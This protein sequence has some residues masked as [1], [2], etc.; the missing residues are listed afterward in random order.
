MCV[1]VCVCVC[2]LSDGS[3]LGA[4]I[5]GKAALIRPTNWSD[6]SFM[7]PSIRRLRQRVEASVQQVATLENTCD[8]LRIKLS[9]FNSDSTEQKDGWE[10]VYCF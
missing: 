3:D 7:K 6:K 1:C 9:T 4:S 10:A 8:S 5:R 2:V